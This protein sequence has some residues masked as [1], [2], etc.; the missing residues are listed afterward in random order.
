MNE[1][2]IIFY[3]MP[4]VICSS[5]ESELIK[6][7]KHHTFIGMCSFLTLLNLQILISIDEDISSF[8]QIE[9]VHLQFTT[10]LQPKFKKFSTLLLRHLTRKTRD[11][12]YQRFMVGSLSWR[13]YKVGNIFY[14]LNLIFFKY[15]SV[16]FKKN[17]KRSQ[18]RCKPPKNCL[19]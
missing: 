2:I 19:T 13:S 9:E 10:N 18:K 15:C 7:F 5:D 3:K 17:E 6:H 14:Y 1:Q 4:N 16:L 8:K 12:I 11:E